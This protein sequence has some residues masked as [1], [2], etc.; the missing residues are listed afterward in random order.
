MLNKMRSEE[1]Y[2][3]DLNAIPIFTAVI[4]QGSFSRAATQLGITKSAVSK[5]VSRLEAEL[6]VSLLHRSTRKLSLTDAGRRFLQHASHARSA[7]DA[8]AAAASELQK[9]PSG[10]LRISLPMSFGKLHVIPRITG[11]LQRYPQIEIQFE[12][13]DDRPD[14]IAQGFDLAVVAGKLEDSALIARK[15]TVHRS[16]ICATPAYLAEHGTPKK[17]SD[18]SSH[19]CLLYSHHTVVNEWVFARKSKVE[20]VS[21]SGNLCTNNSEALRECLLQGLGVGRLPT[22]IASN[23]IAANRL[24]PL[25]N[26]Y[27]MPHKDVYLVIPQ[28]AY[29]PENVRVFMD[30]LLEEVG[31]T[32]PYWDTHAATGKQ[33][34]AR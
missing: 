26:E 5:R 24:V 15:L 8:A 4:E 22:F 32:M 2:M 30:F 12:L 34:E 7:A 25:L 10:L 21:V 1:I 14:V 19:N 23:D 16:V 9:T 3:F 27:A 11:F 13:N 28:R 31:G 29:L 18:L 33:R 20:T 17:P 6:G